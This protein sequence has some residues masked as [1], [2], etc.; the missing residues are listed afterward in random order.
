MTLF[1]GRAMT[2]TE[3]CQNFR[4]S[5]VPPVV[6]A[7]LDFQESVGDWYSGRFELAGSGP[8]TAV[9]WFDGDTEAASQF[10][11]F[12]HGS[13]G[14]SYGFWVY[15]GRSLD[16]APIVFLGSE[17]VG[18][19]VLADN[20]E[21]FLSLLA[22]GDE[23]MGFGAPFLT[24]PQQP[25]AGLIAFRRWLSEQCGITAP[26]HPAA[27]I[28]HAVR[29]HPDLQAWLEK[30]QASHFGSGDSIKGRTVHAENQTK[31]TSLSDELKSLLGSPVEEVTK[32]RFS[33]CLA[34]N[35]TVKKQAGIEFAAK[36]YCLINSIFLHANGDDGFRGYEGELPGGLDFADPQ[37]MVREKLGTPDNSGGGKFSPLFKKQMPMWDCYDYGSFSLHLEYAEGECSIRRLTLMTPDA[38][39]R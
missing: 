3:F 18:C 4:G 35:P 33:T 6:L 25:S 17:G 37:A 24:E 5:I 8:D 15:D 22:V 9:A 13:D 32:G 36:Q 27:I 29:K 20:F 12:G 38:V 39:P 7:L 1:M 31:V 16:N 11:L 19:T 34:A 28:A 10:T 23:E 26:T 2:K 30:W 21:E 14:S